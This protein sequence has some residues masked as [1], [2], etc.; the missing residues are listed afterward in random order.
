VVQK[1]YDDLFQM[2][3]T[4]AKSFLA[5]ARELVVLGYSFSE[6][7]QVINDCFLSEIFSK[8]STIKDVYVFDKEWGPMEKI[9]KYAR[10]GSEQRFH[11]KFM[12]FSKE[13]PNFENISGPPIKIF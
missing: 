1:S 9:L 4:E 3:L 6:N 5:G 7:D 2:I 8:K 10:D 12:D 13:V 11:A